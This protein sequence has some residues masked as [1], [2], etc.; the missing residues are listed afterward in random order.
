MCL[1]FWI[2]GAKARGTRIPSLMA[3]S[4]Y[5]LQASPMCNSFIHPLLHL[6]PLNSHPTLIAF[7]PHTPHRQP[8][9]SVCCMSFYLHLFPENMFCVQVFFSYLNGPVP[10][11]HPVYSFLRGPVTLRSARAVPSISRT[12]VWYSSL[13]VHHISLIRLLRDRH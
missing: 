4:H 13:C 2:W 8:V 5:C 3:H 9:W 12:V 7:L 1:C 10:W 11:F 6:F